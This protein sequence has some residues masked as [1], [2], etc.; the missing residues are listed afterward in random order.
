MTEAPFTPRQ[1]FDDAD[2]ALARV[3]SL[4]QAQV[5][6]LRQHLHDFVAGQEPASRVR[7]A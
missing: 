5:Q 6:H 3:V 1:T 4:Y 7:A 2:A